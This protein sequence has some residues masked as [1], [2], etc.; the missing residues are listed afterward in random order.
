MTYDGIEIDMLALGN[1]D[2]ILVTQWHGLTCTRVLVDGGNCGSF[3]DVR[4]FLRGLGVTR[5]DHVVCTHPHDDHAGGLVPL[6][7]D[8]ALS[9]GAVWCHLAQNHLQMS[10][11]DSA[12]RQTSSFNRSRIIS[13]SLATTVELF[14]AANSR[15]IPIYEPFQGSQIGPLT[16]AGPSVNYYRELV[17]QFGDADAIRS[18][19]HLVTTH[20]T[21]AQ[22]GLLLQVL[23]EAN[24]S[25]E[26]NP[27]TQPENNSSVILVLPHA[28]GVHLL[29]GDAGAQALAC[30]ANAYGLANC[31]WM[32]IPHHGSRRNI[33]QTLIDHFKPNVAFVSAE[34]S[35]KHPRRAVVNAF[36]KTGCSVYSTHYPN[37][38]GLRHSRGTVPQREGYITAT[39]LWEADN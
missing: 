22:A 2:S 15:M 28:S 23:A 36:K 7:Q 4:G 39:A 14:Q 30:A 33:T 24:K 1:A 32:Q 17:A 38:S 31:Q 5:L 19:E 11:V 25:L 10:V 37:K 13:E 35:N 16:V 34:G 29:T 9:I 3:D 21:N 27:Q 26:A 18:T 6:V 20:S 8:R 12:L